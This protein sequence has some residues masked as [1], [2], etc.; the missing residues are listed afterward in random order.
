MP[1]CSYALAALLLGACSSPREASSHDRPAAEAPVRDRVPAV[2]P[3]LD[4]VD[5]AWV[6]RTLASLSLREKVGQMVL[7]WSSGRGDGAG[8]E[9]MRR[10][11]RNVQADGVGGI[12]ISIGSPRAYAAR[13]NALQARAKVPLL[14]VT[15]MESGPGMRLSPG[16]TDF[17]P[18]MALAATGSDSLAFEV[19]RVIGRAGRAAGLHLTLSPVLDVN[20]NPANPIINTRSY[21]EDPRQVAEYAAAYTRGVRAGG[22]LAAGKHFPGH[23]DTHTDSHMDL[24]RIEADAARLRAVELPPFRAAIAAGLDGMLVGHIAVP[25]VAGAGALASLSPQMTTELLRRELGFG[26]IVFTDAM[27]MG[28]LTRRYGQGEAAVLAVQAGADLLLQPTDIPGSIDAVVR[29]VETGRLPAARIDESARRILAAKS[30]A[31]IPGRGPVHADSAAGAADNPATR[32]LAEEVARRSI[33]LVRDR[34][35]RVPLVPAARRIL[36]VSYGGRGA[37]NDAFDRVL[38]AAGRRV[39]SVRLREGATAAQLAAAAA[40]ADSADLVVVSAYVTPRE[41]QGSVEVPA[42]FAAWLQRLDAAGK[43]VVVVSFG[44]PYLLRSFPAVGTFLAAWGG[45]DVSQRAAARALLGQA[46]ITG[47][48]P[49]T[50]PGA[51]RGSGLARPAAR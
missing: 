35:G 47:R 25:R 43:P 32:A 45:A 4:S 17:P 8:S 39:E 31:G 46:P 22:L 18:A 27:N 38:E 11:L 26:G 21:G 10:L 40:R 34:G 49:V 33:T 14:M 13:F 7:A 41:Y 24:P 50:L 6:E 37:P 48:L 23:G 16:G 9:E 5:H 30:R 36:S 12:I 20:S 19:G 2:P 3:A 28:A 29:A 1:F 42:A 51:P 44:S 15:D